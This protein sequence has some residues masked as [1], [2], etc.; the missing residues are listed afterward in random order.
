[1]LFTSKKSSVNTAQRSCPAGNLRTFFC[2]YIAQNLPMSFFS[3]V[4][5]VMMRQEEFSL[6]AIGMLQLIKL[7][8]ILKFLW[9]PIVDRHT[10]TVS[11]Y[12]RWI[13][14]SELIYAVL[15]FAVA[16]LDFKADFPTIMIFLILSFMASATQDIATDALAVLSFHKEDK[17]LI[18]SMQSMGSFS[19][20]LLGGGLLLILFKMW[21]W[22]TI[23]PFLGIFVLIALLPLL[24]NRKIT[25]CS[26]Q[27]RPRA[28]K[29]DLIFFFTQKG[30]WKQIVFL[31]LYYAGLIGTL[32][33][34][35]PYLVDLGYDMHDIGIMSG[36][37]GTFTGFAA[38]FA[39]GFLVRRIGLF[40]AR[41]L[42]AFLIV[43]TTGYF[44]ALSHVT[45]NIALL[46]AGVMLLWG[47][48]GLATI[49]VYTSAMEQ[50]RQGREG[51]DFTLQTVMTHLSGILLAVGS[52]KMADATGYSGLFL[53]ELIVALTSFVFVF[54]A[55]KKN[56]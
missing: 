14:S 45:P 30:I 55:F 16:F 47:S 21:G 28:R 4:I 46:H 43:L 1:M 6:T 22:N 25:F 53:F 23:V 54:F 48:Y 2:L 42:F 50:V 27:E 39:G 52:G 8:W 41:R 40:R 38:S 9:S 31:F 34:L 15:I 44:Y 20:S 56:N 11:D 26:E 17:S 49:V 7:P 51:T 10:R 33:M 18:N 3:T 29:M 24:F 5:P 13:F 19:G 37:I 35:K 12:K 32:A 36:V